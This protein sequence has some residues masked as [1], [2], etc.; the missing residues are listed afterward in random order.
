VIGSTSRGLFLLTPS[1]RVL[2]L[3]YESWRSPLTINLD[4]Q[5][6]LLQKISTGAKAQITPAAIDIPAAGI[7]IDLAHSTR[8]QVPPVPHSDTSTEQQQERLR[9]MGAALIKQSNAGFAALLADFIGLADRPALDPSDQVMLLRI[10]Q[11]QQSLTCQISTLPLSR[12]A[13]CSDMGAD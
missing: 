13:A 7:M 11:L 10:H 9:E 6:A 2:F 5:H 4:N 3:S 1:N 12:P 8:W